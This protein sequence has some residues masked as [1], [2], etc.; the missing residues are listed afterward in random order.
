M[1]RYKITTLGGQHVA[2]ACISLVQVQY[3]QPVMSL[4]TSHA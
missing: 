3:V 2:P 4:L 1:S